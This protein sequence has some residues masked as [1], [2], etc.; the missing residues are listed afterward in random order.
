MRK[1]YLAVAKKRK[2]GGK[3]R[4]KAIKQQ[5]Q[6][7]RRNFRYIEELLDV[8]G[9]PSFPLPHKRQRQYWI[10]Q[11]VYHQQHTMYRNN[12]RRCDDRIVSIH[13]P[14][15]RPIV[16]GKASR[17]VEFGCKLNVSMVEGIA[18]VDRFGWD[19]FNEGTDMI[20]QIEHYKSRYSYY[21]ET[22]LGDGIYG[23]RA[24]RQY[25]KS[26]GIR[27][28]GKPLGRPK[29]KT[30][31]NAEQIRQEKLQRRQ[32]AFERIP[33]EGKFGQGKNGYRLLAFIS[34]RMELHWRSNPIGKVGRNLPYLKKLAWNNFTQ[35]S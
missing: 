4:R 21:P 27:F 12:K 5:L 35:K 3:L 20:A 28:G 16:R 22:V 14:H 33:V 2:P 11:H 25:M 10:I 7:L 8:I 26:K 32:D 30:E 19:A 18:V 9:G 29:K 34:L 13:Q 15:V 23:T 1:N 6:Y 31:A 17:N 24:N